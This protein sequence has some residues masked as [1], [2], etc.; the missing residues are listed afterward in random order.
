MGIGLLRLIDKAALQS[1]RRTIVL[2]IVVL[3]PE[4]VWAG[5]PARG[6]EL[7]HP[8]QLMSAARAG[9]LT[10]VE[11]LLAEGHGVNQALKKSKATPLIF[12]ASA[13]KVEVVKILLDRG[14]NANQCSWGNVCPIWWAVH[15]GS[16]ET[17]KILIDAG[18]KVNSNPSVDA[19]EL[20][21]LQEAVASG[22]QDIIGLLLNH[23]V[24]VDYTNFFAENTPLATA[25]KNGHTQIAQLLID[26]GADLA[27]VVDVP[28]SEAKYYQ[29]R[30]ALELARA[31]GYQQTVH[32][33][34]AFLNSEGYKGKL[35]SVTSIIERLYRDPS[36]DLS[37]QGQS[38]IK[39]LQKQ[40]PETLRRIRN[41][42]FA[43]KNYRFEDQVLSEFFRK[44]FPTYRPMT[45]DVTMS[46]TDRRNVDLLRKIEKYRSARDA[47]G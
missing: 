2:V 7:D 17:T 41:T 16:Y 47:A 13:G 43:R 29:G 20:P 38:L 40:T 30:S 44:N 42:I 33:V 19:L 9:D 39:F 36:F 37:A 6:W 4:L 28:Y 25:V 27:Q 21:I 5:V 24:E 34:E 11:Q 26:H 23:G 1:L 14:A 10:K 46:E 22:H 31:A 15:S 35:V 32:L 45:R 3:L 12:A 8:N 18:A